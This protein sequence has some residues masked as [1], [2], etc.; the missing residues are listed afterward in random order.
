MRSSDDTLG[1]WRFPPIDTNY[2]K[3]RLVEH[4]ESVYTI[5]NSRVL[6]FPAS[7]YKR[8]VRTPRVIEVNA[9]RTNGP[10]RP[11]WSTLSLNGNAQGFQRETQCENI[12]GTLSVCI[13]YFVTFR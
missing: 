5:K 4:G 1:Q 13:T 10:T 2:L 8:R 11:D 3:G 12:T 6:L 9:T 7:V